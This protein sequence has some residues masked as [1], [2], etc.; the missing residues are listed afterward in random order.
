M[1]MIACWIALGLL[2]PAFAVGQNAGAASS[3][4]VSVQQLGGQGQDKD[5]ATK[6]PSGN[7]AEPAAV[8]PGSIL[9]ATLDK[10]VDARKAKVGD[11]VVAKLQ[12]PLLAKGK[13][14]APRGARILGRVTQVQARTKDHPQSELGIVFD[15]IDVK[16]SSA[17]PVA[18]SIQAIS[19]AP[20][21]TNLTGPADAAMTNPMSAGM[22]GRSGNP[23]M[24]GSAAGTV[25]DP[26]A[27]SV[28][29]VGDPSIPASPR[30]NTV[31]H[32]SASSHGIVGISDVEMAAGSSSQGPV[33]RSDKKNVKLDGGDELVL[34][35]Q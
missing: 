32:A 29:N 6:A 12:Q 2:S 15:R 27:S 1:R 21:P 14:I 13:I 34:R 19:G 24:L 8:Q 16:N 33:F 23:G 35:A 31:Q 28:G 11:P 30:I 4:T 7:P 26:S 17:I 9:Y 22:T 3:G 25:S 10:S 5:K 20:L 18:L